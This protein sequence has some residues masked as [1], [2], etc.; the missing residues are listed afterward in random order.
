MKIEAIIEEETTWW[1]SLAKT[2]KV[3]KNSCDY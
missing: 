3:P 2:E 1:I